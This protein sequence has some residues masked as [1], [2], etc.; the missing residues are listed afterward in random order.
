MACTLSV[1]PLFISGEEAFSVLCGMEVW[2]II[3]EMQNLLHKPTFFFLE[4][5]DSGVVDFQ[6]EVELDQGSVCPAFS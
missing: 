1:N 3:F 5:E 6:R 2:W 4:F